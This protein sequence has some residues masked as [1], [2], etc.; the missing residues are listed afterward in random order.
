LIALSIGQILVNVSMEF[1]LES[2]WY[3][4]KKLVLEKNVQNWKLK[5]SIVKTVYW[6]GKNGVVAVMEK[7]VEAKELKLRLSVEAHLVLKQW[8]L[9]K[10]NVSTANWNG[11]N[12]ESVKIIYKAELNLLL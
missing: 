12:G 5:A 8:D 10:K 4:K 6:V 9:K 1:K 7:E 2:L 3:F 11:A